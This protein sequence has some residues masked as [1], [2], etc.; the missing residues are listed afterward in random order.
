MTTVIRA[1]MSGAIDYAGLFPP[2]ARTMA[3]A[4]RNYA[5]YHSG[6]HAWML[7]RFVVPVARLE[8]LASAFASLPAAPGPP[9]PV[10][11]I[12][13]ASDA[14]ALATFNTRYAA[15]LRID[16]VEAPRTSVDGVADLAAIAPLYDVYAEVDA[17]GDPAPAIAACARHCVGAK[18]RTGG[19]T[20]D[21]FPTPRAVARFIRGCVDARVRFKA[22]AGLH[23]AWR[24]E[25]P[26]TYEPHAPRGTMFGFAGVML[27]AA[28]ATAGADEDELVQ[29][30]TARGADFAISNHEIVLPSG[31]TLPAELVAAARHAGIQSFGSCSFDEPVDELAADR[32]L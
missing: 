13:H 6:A 11:V 21:A 19:V 17:T 22:T 18:I 26:L 9:W 28:A 27:A 7:G 20:A 32:L 14:A 2:A 25:Y 30:L 10:S 1:L 31:R 3:D 12:A 24:D 8:E 16:M 15:H 29:A 23:H 5:T 4:V